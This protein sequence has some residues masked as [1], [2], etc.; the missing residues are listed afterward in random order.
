MPEWKDPT[1]LEHWLE[2]HRPDLLDEW[3]V[4]ASEYLDLDEW[5]EREHWIVLLHFH[6]HEREEEAQ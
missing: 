2:K 4:E 6:R 5:L 3:H 1:A